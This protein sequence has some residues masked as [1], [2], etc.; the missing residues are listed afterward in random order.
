[1]AASDDS[2]IFSIQR[3]TFLETIFNKI[4]SDQKSNFDESQQRLDDLQNDL[5]LVSQHLRTLL[6]AVLIVIFFVAIVLMF[7]VMFYFEKAF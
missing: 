7:V 4:S 5:N 6:I 2:H 1:M 3:F